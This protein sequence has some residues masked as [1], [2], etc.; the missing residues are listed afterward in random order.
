VAIFLNVT[1]AECY[2]TSIGHYLWDTPCR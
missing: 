1:G 2:R